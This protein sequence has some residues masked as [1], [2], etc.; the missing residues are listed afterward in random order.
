MLEN[1]SYF[2]SMRMPIHWAVS[3]GHTDM[4]DFLLGLNVP[5]D[6]RDEV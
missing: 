6:A 5:V 1:I 2:Q 4:V 3:G